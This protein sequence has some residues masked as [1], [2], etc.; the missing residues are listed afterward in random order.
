VAVCARVRGG[1]VRAVCAA[2]ARLP[3]VRCCREA[4]WH[5]CAL[6]GVPCWEG[7][8]GYTVSVASGVRV[9]LPTRGR[10]GGQI[11]P[12]RASETVFAGQEGV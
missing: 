10:H 9:C 2:C 6:V 7:R 12:L 3:G 1:G 5:G 8:M 11:L 4:V